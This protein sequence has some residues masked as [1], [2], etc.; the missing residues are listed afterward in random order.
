VIIEILE[1]LLG[2]AVALFG[3]LYNKSVTGVKVLDFLP[4]F[5]VT[6]DWP[7]RRK[8]ERIC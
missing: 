1:S 7:R 4:S 3:I 6:R 8:P 2:V 5:N